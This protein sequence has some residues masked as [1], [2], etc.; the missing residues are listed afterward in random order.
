MEV[1]LKES[2]IGAMCDSR[3]DGSRPRPAID[4]YHA[5]HMPDYVPGGAEFDAIL[6]E[7]GVDAA[8]LS[9]EDKADI[10][11]KLDRDLCGLARERIQARATAKV[12]AMDVLL[13]LQGA[14]DMQSGGA[15]GRAAQNAFVA[16]I[17]DLIDTRL[18]AERAKGGA[19]PAET[20]AAISREIEDNGRADPM[21]KSKALSIV[22]KAAAQVKVE[23]ELAC[24]PAFRDFPPG[25]AW[26]LLMDEHLQ[27]ARGEYGFENEQ[28]YMAGMLNS[29]ARMLESVRNREP[30]DAALFETLHDA[31]V[32][33]VYSKP[34]SMPELAG[35]A[36]D[37]RLKP[38]YR[39]D[40]A[41]I[42][43]ASAL[44]SSWPRR[45]RGASLPVPRPSPGRLEKPCPTPR[46]R[47]AAPRP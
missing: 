21:L 16:T 35:T 25:S 34:T 14:K 40:V 20:L 4:A 3:L 9:P 24:V 11:A 22:D 8:S 2:M 28:G 41:A 15:P 47:S 38:G 18:L 30:I 44:L 33:K 45:S 17:A 1:R 10:A 46:R 31:C 37:G 32:D 19:P 39:T 43:G 36:I 7:L 27:D 42:V 29:F 26:R 12:N 5:R 23:A 13:E 6:G